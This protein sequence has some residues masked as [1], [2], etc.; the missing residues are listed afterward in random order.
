M[1]CT[2]YPLLRP[3]LR[4]A[5]A[6]HIALVD[7]AEATALE[8]KELLAKKML[9]RPELMGRSILDLARHRL[10]VT[11]APEQLVKLAPA[12]LGEPVAV[13]EVETVDV[14]MTAT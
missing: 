1:G 2:H 3:V 5:L 6:P 12:F 11:D 4:A 14:V 9:K 8:V 13:H 10:L 7:G